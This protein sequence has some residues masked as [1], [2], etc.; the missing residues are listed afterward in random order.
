VLSTY[1]GLMI[2]RGLGWT[3][4][5]LGISIMLAL[6]AV[7][8]LL[9]AQNPNLVLVAAIEF[10][11]LLLS[12]V[13]RIWARRRWTHIDWTQCRPSRVASARNA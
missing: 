9:Q 10:K 2:T 7:P 13:L 11:L 3:E 4:S 5:L 12:L 6:M 8:L 1:L